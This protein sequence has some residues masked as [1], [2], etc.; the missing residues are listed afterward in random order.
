MG[1][2]EY[3]IQ[4]EGKMLV[5]RACRH[6]GTGDKGSYSLEELGGT[7]LARRYAASHV[8]SFYSRERMTASLQVD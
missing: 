6:A 8:K 4:K 5:L 2:S 1:W 3:N 7:V